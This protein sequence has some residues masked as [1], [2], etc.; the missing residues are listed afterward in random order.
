MTLGEA[1]RALHTRGMPHY[2]TLHALRDARDPDNGYYTDL[3]DGSM[4]RYIRAT[5]TYEIH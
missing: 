4:L 1:Y 5:N 3:P 2:E